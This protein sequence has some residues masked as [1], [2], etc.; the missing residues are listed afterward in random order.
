VAEDIFKE[1][2][3]HK[4]VSPKDSRIAPGILR[5]YDEYQDKTDHFIIL[6]FADQGELFEHVVQNFAQPKALFNKK[7]IDEWKISMQQMFF[8]ICLGIKKIH[9]KG[10]V[11]RDLSLENLL[12][13]ENKNYEKGKMPK[14]RPV[15]CD[16]GLATKDQK[17]GFREC[18][19]KVGYMSPECA[20]RR[21]SG[22]PNDIWCLGIIFVMML[23]GA[24]PYSKID[25][26]AFQYLIGGAR[27]MNYLFKQYKRDHL[28]PQ[29]A[30]EILLGIFVR[31]RDRLTIEQILETNYCKTAPYPDY[32]KNYKN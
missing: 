23:M 4:M 9:K 11:H 3:Y 24:P 28:I 1:I 7:A 8:E 17:S 10:I 5:I 30:Y 20:N 2:K 12:L 14:L 18:V 15:I 6:E 31:Q 27:R 22:K 26:K 32:W 19:G 16:F 29:N 13:I 25:D 21:Y